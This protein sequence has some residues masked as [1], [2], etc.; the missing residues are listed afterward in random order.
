M[1]LFHSCLYIPQTER[2]NPWMC[3]P[4]LNGVGV[5]GLSEDFQQNR[6]GDKEES[7]K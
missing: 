4:Y 5:A 7:W 6:I 3:T 2:L 1:L